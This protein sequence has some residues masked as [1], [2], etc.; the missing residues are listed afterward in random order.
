MLVIKI[1]R[2]KEFTETSL[3]EASEPRYCVDA[4]SSYPEWC[5]RV[6]DMTDGYSLPCNYLMDAPGEADFDGK[7]AF[8]FIY[9][10]FRDE[11]GDMQVILTRRCRVYIMHEGK[12]VDSI[13]C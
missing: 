12:T 6:R 3:F 5:D 1:I 2:G 8:P 11:R 4:V 10:S 13:V 7:T 9:I